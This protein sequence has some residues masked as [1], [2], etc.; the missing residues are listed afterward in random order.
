[1]SSCN[2]NIILN[3]HPLDLDPFGKE[4]KNGR[5]RAFIDIQVDGRREGRVV[6]ELY[7]DMMSKTCQVFKS[8]CLGRDYM[9][10]QQVEQYQSLGDDK[11]E[12][13]VDQKKTQTADGKDVNLHYKG[14][15]L[16]Y[17]DP[18]K[19]VIMGDV[20]KKKGKVSLMDGGFYADDDVLEVCADQEQMWQ[21]GEFLLAACPLQPPQEKQMSKKE[22]KALQRAREAGEA[23]AEL[24]PAD[25]E[26]QLRD[27]HR[28][29]SQVLITTASGIPVLPNEDQLFQK[30]KIFGRVLKGHHTL[31]ALSKLPIESKNGVPFSEVEISDS[32][33]LSPG[34][35]DDWL[36]KNGQEPYAY[37][38]EDSYPSVPD[39]QQCLRIAN[40]LKSLG[41]EKVKI[42]HYRFAQNIYEKAMRYAEFH[43][44]EQVRDGSQQVDAQNMKQEY[45]EWTSAV[46]RLRVSCFLNRILCM[47][48][49]YKYHQVINDV[50]MLLDGPQSWLF[51]TEDKI[52]LLYRRA[53]AF[54]SSVEDETYKGQKQVDNDFDANYIDLALADLEEALALYTDG[55]TKDPLL[56]Q[57]YEVV[58]RKVVERHRADAQ[59]YSNLWSSS[60]KNTTNN[61]GNV[62]INQS[63]TGW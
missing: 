24:S 16:H 54:V 33:V 41:N 43:L 7:E 11:E 37:F 39:K 23:D 8:L 52:K 46:N 1:M 3:S 36:F 47:Q 62:D 30:P 45:D 18:E 19:M 42:G 15:P 2:N 38:P 20:A 51:N 50:D 35:S 49:N 26:K 56:V 48:K 55:Q 14:A 5:S 28:I 29:T 25:Q 59:K 22:I 21:S 32:G 4:V 10:D 53:M 44:D 60:D 13:K 61:S 58:K 17:I 6:F 40:E 31:I 34:Q 27:S 57:Q 63:S 12:H 9:V